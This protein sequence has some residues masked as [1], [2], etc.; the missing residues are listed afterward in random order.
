[1]RHNVSRVPELDYFARKLARKEQAPQW[2]LPYGKAG[3]AL[4]LKDAYDSPTQYLGTMQAHTTL[5]FQAR[6]LGGQGKGRDARCDWLQPLAQR[7]AH[8]S[9]TCRQNVRALRSMHARCP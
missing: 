2:C 9:C 8:A 6:A 4:G 1:M 7:A 3:Q 5:E